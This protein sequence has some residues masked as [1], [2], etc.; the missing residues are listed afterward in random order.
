MILRFCC[1]SSIQINCYFRSVRGTYRTLRMNFSSILPSFF[2][3]STNFWQSLI[4]PTG[5]IIL[6]PSASCSIKAS[7]IFSAAAPTCMTSNLISLSNV[8]P[9]L[10]S[11]AYIL[12]F[13]INSGF[14]FLIFSIDFLT[15]SG[16]CSIPN[17]LDYG[18]VTMAMAAV[19]YPV[20]LPI[21]REY[22]AVVSL[23]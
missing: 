16:T 4:P 12:I 11:P 14:P 3:I 2:V 1:Q 7:G 6:P 17:T 5:I 8:H 20:P 9:N 15:S 10:P 18:G 22:L 13:S 21:S 23:L 19:R